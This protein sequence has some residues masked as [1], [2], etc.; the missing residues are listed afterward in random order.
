MQPEKKQT[1]QDQGLLNNIQLLCRE[2]GKGHGRKKAQGRRGES[3]KERQRRKKWKEPGRNFQG[4]GHFGSTGDLHHRALVRISVLWEQV[5]ELHLAVQEPLAGER[6][7]KTWKYLPLNWQKL[8]LLN[9]GKHHENPALALTKAPLQGLIV[10][11]E[12]MMP[13]PECKVS[14]QWVGSWG[15]LLGLSHGSKCRARLWAQRLKCEWS[16]RAK[17]PFQVTETYQAEPQ[18]LTLWDWH[19]GTSECDFRLRESKRGKCH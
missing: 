19:K 13:A 6:K 4:S 7:N 16:S 3:L 5:S 17:Q 1:P 12:H 9:V 10:F 2:R 11:I 15:I 14:R 8:G 18:A